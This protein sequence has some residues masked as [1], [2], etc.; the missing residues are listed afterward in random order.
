VRPG[1]TDKLPPAIGSADLRAAAAKGDAAAE[2][3]IA[4]RLADGRGVPR[5]LTAAAEWF[6]R[7]A[8]Q[9]LA[10]AQV[11]LGSLYEKGLGVK[12]DIETARR[13]YQSAAEA[14]NARAMHNLAVL[15]AEGTD[16]KPDYQNAAKWFRKAAD[17]GIVDSQYN[18]AILYV[19]GIGIEANP[20]EAYRWFT[21]AAQGG[22]MEAAKKRE[23]MTARLDRTTL[24]TARA[25]A[26]AWA[27]QAPIEAATNVPSPAGGWD[28]SAA[29]PLN[30]KNRIGGKAEATP[31]PSIQ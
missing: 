19:R 23:D 21:I 14:G 10:P 7:A 13:H 16:T 4:T 26:Q 17:Y 8:K 25:D 5:D 20:G 9:G 18:L 31:P 28:K 30:G 2:F 15:Y 6:E 1:T 29:A 12:K 24:A 22:D 3:E 27:P 11:R